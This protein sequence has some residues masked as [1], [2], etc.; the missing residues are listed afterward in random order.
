MILQSNDR[1]NILELYG[2]QKLV[3]VIGYVDLPP[4][5]DLTSHRFMAKKLPDSG[6]RP[7]PCRVQIGK[8]MPFLVAGID[9]GVMQ[10]KMIMWHGL[11][12]P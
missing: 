4:E 11:C 10:V 3:V 1:E 12:L 5:I 2:F 9:M 8:V 7:G 6:R